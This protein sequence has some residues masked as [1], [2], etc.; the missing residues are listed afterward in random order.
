MRR[1]DVRGSPAPRARPPAVAV[2]AIA[3]MIAGGAA[4]LGMQSCAQTP[5]AQAPGGTLGQHPLQQID[6]P[7]QPVVQPDPPPQPRPEPQRVVQP[8]PPP[9]PRPEP[10]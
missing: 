1:S 5:D 3:M 8:D 10:Q 6:P 4:L 9:Q 2:A 7:R